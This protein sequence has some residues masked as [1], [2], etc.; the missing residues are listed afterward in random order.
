M[1]V[2]LLR[3]LND[4]TYTPVGSTTSRT[5]DVRI[6]AATNRSLRDMVRVGKMREDFFHRLHVIAVDMPP[7]RQRKEDIPLLI[8][9]FLTQSTPANQPPPTI[10]IEIVERF[11]A[12]DWPGN[13]RELHNALRRYLT[14]GEI[15]LQTN[16]AA[17]AL[18]NL[19]TEMF[20]VHQTFDEAIA[21][22][23]KHLIANALTQTGRNIAKTATLLHIPLRTLHRKIKAYQL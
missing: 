6:I 9:H 18:R 13:V 4:Y 8:A 11:C 12:Y 16:P 23:E 5:A 21:A 17:N 19:T 14:T 1:Q 10:P 22:V 7:L 3:V 2:K 15:E 20:P